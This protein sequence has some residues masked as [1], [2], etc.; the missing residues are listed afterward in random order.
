ML[1]LE[2]FGYEKACQISRFEF[3]LKDHFTTY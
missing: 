3:Q 2:K 1:R